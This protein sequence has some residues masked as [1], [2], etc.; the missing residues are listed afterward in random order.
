MMGKVKNTGQVEISLSIKKLS[1]EIF[2]IEF[3][4]PLEPGEYAFVP[5][6]ASDLEG[7]ELLGQTVFCFGVDG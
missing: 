7:T 4:Q 1:D 6:K 2:K 5:F 3:D